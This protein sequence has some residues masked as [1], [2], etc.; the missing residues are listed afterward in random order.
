MGLGGL[1]DLAKNFLGAGGAVV[2]DPST[3]EIKELGGQERSVKLQGWG[4]PR[5]PFVLRT[6]QRMSTVWLPGYAEGTAT[7]LGPSEEPTTIDGFW[8]DRYIG[9]ASEAD[10]AGGLL[11]DVK[12]GLQAVS[13]ALSGG[14]GPTDD[15]AQ[16]PITVDGESITSCRDASK[17]FDSICR[18]GQEL[19]VSWDT[20]VRTGHL[21]AF[22]KTWHNA[23][24]LEWTME[25]EWTGRGERTPPADADSQ[26][27]GDL[28]S[29]IEGGLDDLQSIANEAVNI[30]EELQD[31]VIS[32]LQK[33]DSIVTG[34]ATA[35]SSIRANVAGIGTALSNFNLNLG[36]GSEDAGS[37]GGAGAS[38]NAAS[39]SQSL[40]QA[41]TPE[42]RAR[43]IASLLGALV[44]AA[45]E[46]GALVDVRPYGASH[47]DAQPTSRFGGTVTYQAAIASG[48]QG[49][50]VDG[51]STSE[52]MVVSDWAR[53]YR[54]SSLALRDDAV[55]RRAVLVA[56]LETRVQATYTARQGDDLRDV[57]RIFYGSPF[58]W[59]RILLFNSLSNTTLVPGQ[60]VLV[61]RS[62]AE[63]GVL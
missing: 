48:G 22:E 24:D 50:G 58:D 33:I 63:E 16:S 19:E 38:S 35:V 32:Q 1:V 18:E 10:P 4:L 23:H 44:E 40:R 56:T 9:K 46:S 52:R 11:G 20:Q 49:A 8:H 59:R 27:G 47:R 7:I 42:Q 26:S 5:R 53:R 41:T 45:E 14:F 29:S 21:K 30:S 54:E 62:T 3:F 25:F 31:A 60:L 51:I 2:A 55:A 13:G 37:S 17:L 6:T 57:A 39:T 34:I 36:T 28:F 15:A 12:E 61:P 43:D